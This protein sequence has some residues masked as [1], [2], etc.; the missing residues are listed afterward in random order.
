MITIDYKTAYENTMQEID[1]F[2]KE[3]ADLK[4]QLAEKTER[5]GILETRETALMDAAND[6]RQQLEEKDTQ[7]TE[8]WEDIEN[9]RK[10]VAQTKCLYLDEKERADKAEA[11]LAQYRNFE[12]D[13]WKGLCIAQGMKLKALGAENAE[14]MKQIGE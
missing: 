9:L 14:L 3:L 11:E 4:K 8:A 2:E 1:R 12:V 10:A 13:D 7:L 5:I 6:L